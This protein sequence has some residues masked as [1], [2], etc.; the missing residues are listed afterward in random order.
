[1][2]VTGIGKVSVD[3]EAQA[4]TT[5]RRGRTAEL[6][7]IDRRHAQTPRRHRDNRSSYHNHSA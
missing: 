5:M 1:M 6:W 2:R 7:K 3:G 4:A